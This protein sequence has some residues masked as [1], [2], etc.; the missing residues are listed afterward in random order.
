M[1][2]LMQKPPLAKGA[3]TIMPLAVLSLVGLMILP[4]PAFGLDLLISLNISLSLVVLLTTVYVVNP[5]NFSVF[6][7]VLLLLTVFRLALNISSTRRILLKGYEGT[8]AAGN[9]IEAFGQFVVGGNM[10]VGLVIFLV[11]LA[12]QFIVI[13]HGASRISEVAARFTLDAMPGK[14]MAIDADL[15]AGLIDEKDA[16]ER[17]QEIQSEADF[18]GA[19]DGAVKFTQR[20]AIASMIIVAINV[21]AGLA[22]G[23]MQGGMSAIEALSTYTVLTVGDG[24]V[25]AIPSL[26]ISVAGALITTRAGT[27]EDLGSDVASQLFSNM[28][29][30]AVAAGALG[31]MA[32]IPGLPTVPFLTLGAVFGTFSFL[33]HR[34]DNSDAEQL[35]APDE[36][37]GLPPEEPIEPL[38]MI[39]PLTIE[40]GYDLVD[41]AGSERAGGVLDRI[42]GIRRQ[43]ASDLGVVV[44]PVRVRDNLRLASDE[45]RILLRGSEIGKSEIPR[46][47]VLAIDPGD[48]LNPIDGMETKDPAFGIPALWIDSTQADH[49]RSIGYTVVDRTS[50]MGTHLSELVRKHA[51]ELLGRQETQALLD[52]LS[53]SAPKLVEELIPERFSLGQ[54][55]KV[56]QALL[57]ER[58]SIRDLQT[59][60]EALADCG[61]HDISFD[62][63]LGLVRQALAR[64][65]VLP[66]AEEN[67]LAVVTLS[68]ELESQVRQLANGESGGN[69]PV[70]T[71]P[72]FTQALVH[73]VAS[74]VRSAP[75]K[76]QP[77]VLC[78]S[79]E[80]R[81]LLRRLTQSA[82]PTVPFLAVQEVPDGV[83]VHAVGQ[84]T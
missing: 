52:V 43:V 3:Q 83:R 15:N 42:R 59:I 60:C 14:Q 76:S 34:H 81:F 18:Y 36:T 21:I 50:V 46:G 67:E 25:S 41:M 65:L 29:P 74:A 66:L 31:V 79:S 11:L 55:Q 51:P 17:R 6:P 80:S 5:V 75:A 78:G 1:S 44:P 61:G 40:V 35:E 24:L 56:L 45:Y 57:R 47:R 58:V 77:A 68:S 28:R 62:R 22:I 72:Q 84:V 39:D 82:L 13:N 37:P 10:V 33:I 7:S 70:P 54:V 16:K 4:L 49:A 53:K 69:L 63:L 8:D 12:V 64:S 73:R 9:V 23:V 20:D 48:A 38:L 2:G 27:T 30:M 71:D 26:F 19:M 32:L